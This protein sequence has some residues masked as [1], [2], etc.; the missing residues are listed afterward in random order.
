MITTSRSDFVKEGLVD[1]IAKNMVVYLNWMNNHKR[2]GE[3]GKQISVSTREI[4]AWTNFINQL[5]LSDTHKKGEED[6]FASFVHGAHMVILDGLGMG[7]TL[8]MSKKELSEWR[9]ECSQ[10]LLDL[11][12]SHVREA[13]EGRQTFLESSS[14]FDILPNLSENTFSIGSF[15]IPCKNEILSEVN[16]ESRTQIYAVDARKTVFN[17]GRILRAM[18]SPRPILLEGPPGVGK[19]SLI[20][21]LAALTGHCLTRVNLSEHSELS[22]LLGCDLPCAAGG[23]G[24][25]GDPAQFRWCDGVFL[26]AM[27]QGHWVLLDELNL[28][29]QSVLEVS[30]LYT[31]FFGV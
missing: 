27:K 13:F 19:T 6:V 20:A 7:N 23:N 10:Y 30:L 22:D 26:R 16:T 31:I 1:I 18:Q 5:I 17:L 9:H 14:S 28:A 12:P 29:P 21:N 3:L 25:D 4:L 8:T 2:L 24:Q 15:S 11:C